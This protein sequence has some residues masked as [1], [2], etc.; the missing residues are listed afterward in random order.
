MSIRDRLRRWLGIIDPA[1]PSPIEEKPLQIRED[2]A[3]AFRRVVRKQPLTL[4]VPAPGVRPKDAPEQPQLAMDDAS[5]SGLFGW[6]G[7]A[8]S[9]GSFNLY[10]PGYPYLA[11]LSQRSEYLEPC[12]EIASEMTR[13]WIKFKST[14]EDDVSEKLKAIEQRFKDLNVREIFR[15][16]TLL[17]GKFGRAQV[18]I[19]FKNDAPEKRADPL[20]VD[21]GGFTKG[22]L[23]ALKLIEP[24]WTSPSQWNATD[25]MRDDFY[26]PSE[27]YVMGTKVHAS[28]LLTFVSRKVPDIL[29]PSYNFGGLSLI[30]LMQPY[31]DQWLRTRDSISDLVHNFS[32]IALQT[33]MSAVLQNGP[34][35]GLMR[36]AQ[37]FTDT[38]ENRALMMLDKDREELVQ[39]AVPLGG[40]HDLQAQSQ[41]HMCAPTHLPMVKLTGITP[42]G[43]NVSSEGEITV[44]YDHLHSKQENDY[45]TNLLI[46][47]H[48]V[49]LDLYGSIDPTIAYEFVP[50]EEPNGKEL[51]EERASDAQAAATYAEM[52]A[53]DPDEVRERLQHDP[54]S[55]Y[56]NLSGPAPG[57]PEE[58]DDEEPKSA[59][60]AA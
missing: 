26:V 21:E 6:M 20:V 28:R 18:F 37:M 16:A 60:A 30:Q 9:F 17:D 5:I 34:A 36:R 53:I 22:T 10:F 23:D 31:V 50:L 38:R 12:S 8:S 42:S 15:D 41:E 3:A 52:G 39:V 47:L 27:W 7:Q 55:G 25:P 58:P 59:E 43:L 14:S 1:P 44:F 51:A 56:D 49:Q 29:K 4:P 24:V 45:N 33:D 32:I 46:V 57:P 13:K 2:A 40:L 11:E 35:D 19:R 48:L 54:N